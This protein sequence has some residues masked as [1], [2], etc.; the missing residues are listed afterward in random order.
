[1]DGR[2]SVDD[3]GS[4]PLMPMV[5]TSRQGIGGQLTQG[6]RLHLAVSQ[7]LGKLQRD[8]NKVTPLS[9]NIR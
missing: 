5:C 3:G 7:P 8:I 9:S 6:T 4:H 2:R 1:M